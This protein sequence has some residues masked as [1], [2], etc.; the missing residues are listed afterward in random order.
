MR[1]RPALRALL[2]A[3]ALTNAVLYAC[4]LPLWEGFDEPFHYG[5]V[6]WISV[7]HRFPIMNR[8]RI[9]SEIRKSFDFIPLSRFLSAA[10]PGS[11]SFEQWPELS[12]AEKQRRKAELNQIRPEFRGKESEVLNYEAQQAPLAYLALAPFDL[13]L[14]SIQIR[15]RILWLRLLAGIAATLAIFFALEKLSELLG[16]RPAFAYAALACVFEVQMLWASVAHVGNDSLAVPLTVWFLTWLLVAAQKPTTRNV[17]ILAGIL[18]VGLLTKA[19]FLAFAPVTAI[20]ILQL[21]I[22]RK[23]SGGLALAAAALVLLVAGPWY[24]RNLFLYRSLSGT[25]Q[26]VAGIGPMQAVM[27]VPRINWPA[28]ILRF[29]HWSLWTGNWSFVS[30]SKATLDL[31]LILLLTAA[32]LYVAGWRVLRPPQAWM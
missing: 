17:L 13:L 20:L 10:I 29:A 14:R 24:A 12:D 27:A 15:W 18:A 8:T 2:F 9:S 21:F 31:E 1:V 28:S 7:E 23:T 11:V 4:I 16:A 25:Q 5:Y 19:Y 30:F 6:Q 22:Q 26:S 32:F 3:F